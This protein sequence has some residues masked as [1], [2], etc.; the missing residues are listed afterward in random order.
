MS[1]K[2]NKKTDAQPSGIINY[3]NSF[4]MIAKSEPQ[5]KR[6]PCRLFLFCFALCFGCRFCRLVSAF[7]GVFRRRLRF[8][9]RKA[10]VAIAGHARTGRNQ[11]AD[12]DV[13]FQTELRI[14]FTFDRSFRENACGFLEGCGGKERI[15]R[16]GGFGNTQE[17]M[18]AAGF[19][20]SFGT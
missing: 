11:F 14:D 2:R 6:R 19:L 18:F 17:D 3:L 20:L 16:K 4:P 10:D 7:F 5:K 12:D 9:F 8:V 1:R 15:G 13:F